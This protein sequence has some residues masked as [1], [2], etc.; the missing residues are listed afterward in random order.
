LIKSLLISFFFGNLTQPI[1]T[2]ESHVDGFFAKKAPLSS[3]GLSI[4]GQIFLNYQSSSGKY[5]RGLM[6]AN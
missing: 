4:G 6:G 2:L 1:Y 5:D 3:Y